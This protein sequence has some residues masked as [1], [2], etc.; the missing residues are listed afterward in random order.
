MQ[1]YYRRPALEEMLGLSRSTIYRMM[2]HG[3]F[4]RPVLLG[5]RAVGWLEDDIDNWLGSKANSSD[6]KSS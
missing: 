1:R 3:E 2:Q 4:P 5:R 6:R